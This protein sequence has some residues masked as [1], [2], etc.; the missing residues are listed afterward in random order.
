MTARGLLTMFAVAI[1]GAGCAAQ[2]PR[3]DPDA[4]TAAAS[5]EE[6]GLM[7]V[8]RQSEQA[9]AASG[10][11]I[12]DAGLAEY[13]RE[14]GCRVAGPY[15]PDVRIYT[16]TIPDFNASMAPNGFMQVW[17][18]LLLRVE[19]EAQLASVLGHETSHYALRHSLERLRTTQRTAN[20]LLAA[21][22]GLFAQGV[23]GVSVGP[24]GIS[25]GDLGQL[26]ASGYLAAYSRDQEAEA[27][28][29][30]HDLMVRAGYAPEEAAA[31][32][33]NLVAE[34]EA[35]DLPTPPALFAS[36]PPSEERMR[37]LRAMADRAGSEG[38]IGRERYLAATMPHRGDWLRMSLDRRQLCRTRVV[39]ERLL[40]RP[41][42]HGVLHYYQGELYRLRDQEG[43]LNK[44]IEAYR[45]ALDH[46]DAP[47]ASWRA[48]G[49]ALWRND[50]DAGARDAFQR[51]LNRADDPDDA[52]MVRSYLETLP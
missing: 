43:D 10:L 52:A 50:D 15:C 38:E 14:V 48:L 49:L 32:W 30:G 27:D 2:A 37:E 33:R 45:K 4:E 9:F 29:D 31:V 34:Q 23:G 47:A 46:D 24:V 3:I 8:S 26:L 7:L 20:V 13:V 42:G 18:G 25:A 6:E 5:T 11:V 41:E 40:Q 19:N 35:C 22:M 28:S 1:L 16:A 21:Q 51:Y 39:I 44:A 12:D 17:T 36:H